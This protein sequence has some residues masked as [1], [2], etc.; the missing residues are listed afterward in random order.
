M[1]QVFKSK[2]IIL[3]RIQNVHNLINDFEILNSTKPPQYDWIGVSFV[4]CHCNHVLFSLSLSCSLFF[5]VFSVFLRNNYIS[6][7]L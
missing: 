4:I 1:C 7:S 3:L 5:C 6:L 2:A